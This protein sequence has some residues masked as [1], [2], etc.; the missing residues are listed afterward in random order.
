[1][2][3][4]LPIENQADAFPVSVGAR[5]AENIPQGVVFRDAY[6]ENSEFERTCMDNINIIYI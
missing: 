2:Q 6:L 5:H 4:T 1:M 3:Q